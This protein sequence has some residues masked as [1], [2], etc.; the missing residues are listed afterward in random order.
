MHDVLSSIL[1][2]VKHGEGK[3]ALAIRQVTGISGAVYKYGKVLNTSGV[4]IAKTFGYEDV[5][6]NDLD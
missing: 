3:A 5:H 4:R 6:E 1:E 2:G